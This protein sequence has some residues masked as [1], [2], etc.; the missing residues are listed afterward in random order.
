MS[1]MWSCPTKIHLIL[2]VTLLSC[3]CSSAQAQLSLCNKTDAPIHL[4]L[5]FANVDFVGSQGWYTITPGECRVLFKNGLALRRYAYFAK[6][7]DFRMAYKPGDG[8]SFCIRD[9]DKFRFN[10][11]LTVKGCEKY[12]AKDVLFKT[13]DTKDFRKFT[14][15]FLPVQDE[16]PV[17]DP[18]LLKEMV[19][20]GWWSEL[21]DGGCAAHEMYN[22]NTKPIQRIENNKVYLGTDDPMIFESRGEKLAVLHFVENGTEFHH[23]IERCSP[24]KNQTGR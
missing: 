1:G 15:T 6:G 4:A 5:G 17:T 14:F 24:Q 22:L 11:E 12:G 8:T 16:A 23:R 21:R 20:K 13:I 19:K 18:T 10:M 9:K 2:L 3:S 7:D